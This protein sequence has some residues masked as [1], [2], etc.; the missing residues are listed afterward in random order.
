[1]TD[2]FVMSIGPGSDFE[3]SD[4][5]IR[6]PRRYVD[7]VVETLRKAGFAAEEPIEHGSDER[8]GVKITVALLQAGTLAALATVLATIF[9]RHDNKRLI[10]NKEEVD[11]TGYT[12]EDLKEILRAL[13]PDEPSTDDQA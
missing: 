10:V 6:V 1:M 8:A 11:A 12:A 5:C 7:E 13:Y 4:F 2:V 9:G 3:G